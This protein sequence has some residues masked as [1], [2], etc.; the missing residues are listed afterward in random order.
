MIKKEEVEK[1]AQLARL[2]LSSE[3]VTKL[4][5]ELSKI[6]GYIDK[7]KELKTDKVEPVS[8]PFNIR[9]VMRPDAKRSGKRAESSKLLEA[10]PTTKDQ[11]LKVKAVLK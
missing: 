3:E 10:G 1:I 4:Q 5:T 8:H 9:N 2:G 6:F 11:Y 7:L